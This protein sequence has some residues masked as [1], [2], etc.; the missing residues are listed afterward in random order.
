MWPTM[1]QEAKGLNNRKFLYTLVPKCSPVQHIHQSEMPSSL[2]G[3]H[4]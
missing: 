3:E 1:D 2:L 4:C